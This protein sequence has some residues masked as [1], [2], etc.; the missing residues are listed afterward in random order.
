MTLQTG[1]S[2][3]IKL[4]EQLRHDACVDGDRDDAV[5]INYNSCGTIRV[6]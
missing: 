4:R 1:E 3:S 6:S 5:V 2:C